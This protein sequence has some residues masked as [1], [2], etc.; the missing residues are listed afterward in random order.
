MSFFPYQYY[1]GNAKLA[2]SKDIEPDERVIIIDDDLITGGTACA[3][4]E[5]IGQA[6]GIVI[7]LAFA[8]EWLGSGGREK[9]KTRDAFSALK[10]WH[11]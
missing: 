10:A 6:G 2:F 3:C 9:L 8:I 11:V 5:V 7:G 1:Y 4:I